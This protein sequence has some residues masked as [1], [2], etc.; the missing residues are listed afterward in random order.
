MGNVKK[1][2]DLLKSAEVARMFHVDPKTVRRWTVSGKLRAAA[3][4]PG[5]QYRYSKTTIALMLA[6]QS[7]GDD[8]E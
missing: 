4:T 8:A 7:E 1:Y 6:L 3:V 5:G 2:A